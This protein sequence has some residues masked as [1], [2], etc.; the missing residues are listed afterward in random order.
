MWF[1][2]MQ[3]PSLDVQNWYIVKKW[4]KNIDGN[5][6]FKHAKTLALQMTMSLK[7]WDFKYMLKQ[8][9]WWELKII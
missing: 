4:K 5:V 1:H 6:L 8:S 3:D 7:L 2:W 9:F